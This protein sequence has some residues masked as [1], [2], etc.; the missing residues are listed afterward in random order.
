MYL[1]TVYLFAH[2]ESLEYQI[3]DFKKDFNQW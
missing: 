1:S 2:A 3:G